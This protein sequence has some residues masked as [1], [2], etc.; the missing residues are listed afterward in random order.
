MTLL[1]EAFQAKPDSA[2]ASFFRYAYRSGCNLNSTANQSYA[3]HAAEWLQQFD[4]RENTSESYRH[5]KTDRAWTF[6]AE[7]GDKLIVRPLLVDEFYFHFL[8]SARAG[9]EADALVISPSMAF[10]KHVRR[11]AGSDDCEHLT[12]LMPS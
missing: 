12:S 10:I 5:G 6:L 11:H 7:K 3:R 9:F 1:D 8:I 2:A 4:M